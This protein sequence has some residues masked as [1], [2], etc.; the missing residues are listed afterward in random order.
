[1][2]YTIPLISIAIFFGLILTKYAFYILVPNIVFSIS[3]AIA[4]VLSLYVLIDDIGDFIINL[5]KK[6]S[7]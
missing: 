5:I 1:M 6:C 2:N 4:V 7:K 3:G